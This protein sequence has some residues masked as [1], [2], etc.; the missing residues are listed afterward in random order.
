MT[1]DYRQALAVATEAALQAGVLLREEFHRTGGP[2]SPKGHCPADDTAEELIRERLLAAFP[3]WGYLGEETG[4]RAAAEGEPHIWLVD[5]NDGT[6]SFQKGMRGSAVSIALLR[7]GEPVLGVVYA[8]AAPDDGGDLFTWAEACPLT[9]QGIPVEIGSWTRCP[10]TQ[11]I[12]L[13]SQ[14]AD[15]HPEANLRCIAPM[16][17]RAVPSIAYRLA[18]VAAGEGVAGV[19]LNGPCC[20]DYAAGHALIKGA[21]GELIDQGGRPVR[22]G[23]GGRSVTHCCLGGDPITV[24]SLR[25]RPWNSVLDKSSTSKIAA[26]IPSLVRLEPGAALKDAGLISRA[27]G[28]LLGQLAGDALGS[29]VEFK[30]GQTLRARYT[31]GVRA[32]DDGGTWNTMAGQPTDDSEMALMLARSL[33]TQGGYD[34]EAVALSYRFWY[35]S[36]PFDIGGTTRQALGAT[37]GKECASKAAMASA[38][39][40]SQANGSLMRV[41]PL[42]IYGHNLPSQT[43]ADLARLDSSLTH[44][45]PACQEASAVFAVAVARA[46]GRGGTSEEIYADTLYWA[47]ANC[48]EGSVLDTLIRA[49][50]AAPDSYSNQSGWVLIALQNAFYQLI[51]APNLEE[52]VVATIM[53]GGDTDTN[54]A[55]AGALLGAVHGRE[56]IPR[57]WRTM[58]LSCRPVHGLSATKHPRP[59]VFWPVDAQELAER[60]A[61]ISSLAAITS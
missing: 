51:H 4:A 35:Q 8:F 58:V 38:S 20:W 34:M 40:S 46:V 1:H 42:G 43:V 18:L 55:I 7:Q 24:R 56:A 57:Q 15:E 30:S 52:G 50:L 54:A 36:G 21:G 59:T 32:M 28:C 9:R 47:R 23:P 16:R 53:A 49:R 5:P 19:S 29:L 44:P 45:H 13:I 60:L 2:S 3:T 17:Y 61:A 27:Q 37:V 12:V 48:R 14:G 26:G 6:R 11:R 22:Y 31:G 10:D 41:S 39:R 25:E 33:L